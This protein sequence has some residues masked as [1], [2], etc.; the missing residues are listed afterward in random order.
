[1]HP[2]LCS[3]AFVDQYSG[4]VGLPSFFRLHMPCGHLPVGLQTNWLP[5]LL[6][7]QL[8]LQPAV[9]PQGPKL[10]MAAKLYQLSAGTVGLPL[11]AVCTVAQ[12]A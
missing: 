1:V 12:A 5:S 6:Q 2:H 4:L 8:L 9:G 11:V 3:P 7:L 10:L